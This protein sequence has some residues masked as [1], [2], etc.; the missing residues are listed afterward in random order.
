MWVKQYEALVRCI[1]KSQ[2]TGI[3]SD[4]ATSVLDE[5]FSS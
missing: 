3:E 5:H 2:E 1:E 4:H